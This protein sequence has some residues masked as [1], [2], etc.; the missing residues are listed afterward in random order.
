MST[1]MTMV[2]VMVVTVT[3]MMTS[4]IN[5][6][7]A[8]RT[9][10]HRCYCLSFILS[11]SEQDYC[12]SNHPISLKLGVVVGPTNRKNWLTFGG[13]QV[14]GTDFGL[15]CHFPHHCGIRVSRDL[16]TFLIQSPADFHDTPRNDW[17]WQRNKS[18]T[19]WVRSG[20]HPDPNPD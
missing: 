14:P 9:L 13:D 18:A 1:I 3:L 17:H 19:S 12:K 4:F 6:A 15:L 10:C 2:V 5:S 8:E 20:R 11:V 7:N 16:L